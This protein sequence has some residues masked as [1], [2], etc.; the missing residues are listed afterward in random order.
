MTHPMTHPIARWTR[1]VALAAAAFG[2]LT[3]FSGSLVLFGPR[4]AQDAAGNAVPFVVIF[5]TAAGF[6]YLAGAVA[7]WRNHPSA[8]SIAIVIGVATLIVLAGFAAT[9]LTGAPVELRTALALPFRAAFW[10]VI[11][12]ALGRQTHAA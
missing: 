11:A 12:W 9:A 2:A 6:A 4:A 5:N 1:P 10:L 7:I 3:I 8:R